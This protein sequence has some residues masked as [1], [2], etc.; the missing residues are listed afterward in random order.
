MLDAGKTTALSGLPWGL[1]L[2]V[3]DQDNLQSVQ[4]RGRRGRPGS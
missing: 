2:Q 3:W 4:L 1:A